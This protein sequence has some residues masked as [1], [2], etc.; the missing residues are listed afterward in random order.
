MLMPYFVLTYDVVDDFINKRTPFRPDHLRMAHE[1]AARGE[2][3]M[4]GALGDPAGSMLIFRVADRAVV[5]AFATSDPYVTQGL[6]RRWTVRPW[7]VV[8]GQDPSETLP[9]LPT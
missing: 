9:G 4:A 6:V 3:I 8:I 5:E 1:A 2:L 7:T